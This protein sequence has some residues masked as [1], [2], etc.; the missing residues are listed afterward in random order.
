MWYDELITFSLVKSAS[1]KHMFSAILLGLDVTPP[2]YTG[3]GWFI[4]HYLAPEA[5]PELLLRITNAA[6]IAATLWILYLL[7]R[8][9]FDQVTALTTIATFTL[10]ELWHLKFLT[11][12]IRTYAALSFSRHWRFTLP[13]APFPVPLGRA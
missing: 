6:L 13:C 7:V 12:E 2:L 1:L 8:R 3:Y 5:S 4:L 11:L 10:L 9:Y